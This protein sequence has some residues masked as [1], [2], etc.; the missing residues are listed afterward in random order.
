[1]VIERDKMRRFLCDGRATF[2]YYELK[3]GYQWRRTLDDFRI[4]ELL[5]NQLN[6]E[7]RDK[8]NPRKEEFAML[9]QIQEH[10]S[11]VW[12]EGPLGWMTWV[13]IHHDV[14]S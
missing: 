2:Y 1:M 12:M 10:K 6:K 4:F 5:C 3:H 11:I 7:V 14:L 8:E 9:M 13:D